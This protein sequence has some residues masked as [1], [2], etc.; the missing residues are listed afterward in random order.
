M[1]PV[2]SMTPPPNAPAIPATDVA[3]PPA[4]SGYSRKA[5][6]LTLLRLAIPVA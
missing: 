5:T 6:A 2:V 4:V 1:G 3:P